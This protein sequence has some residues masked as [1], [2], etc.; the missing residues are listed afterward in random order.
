MEAPKDSVLEKLLQAHRSRS[1][2]MI[3]E[4]TNDLPAETPSTPTPQ[5]QQQQPK[6]PS[7]GRRA[8]IQQ[9][10]VTTPTGASTPKPAAVNEFLGSVTHAR[11]FHQ[12][13]IVGLLE[14]CRGVAELYQ[15]QQQLS[16]ISTD[17]HAGATRALGE[18]LAYLKLTDTINELAPMYSKSLV[19]SLLVFLDRYNKQ[20]HV[21][22]QLEARANAEI[23]QERA[24]AMK[25]KHRAASQ[26]KNTQVVTENDNPF[27][28]EEEGDKP[29]QTESSR[30]DG[31]TSSES[32][33]SDSFNEELRAAQLK[34]FDLEEEKA[35][36]M[37]LCKQ[38]IFDWELLDNT[39]Q[40]GVPAQ[41]IQRAAISVADSTLDP[42]GEWIYM[43]EQ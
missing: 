30:A 32:G 22:Q 15:P 26:S 12:T 31:K 37:Q 6:N 25:E 18:V 14:A 28:G 2:K 11:K 39:L 35:A 8:S 21:Y 17:P 42:R 20:L 9:K 36:W 27:E 29:Q 4:F 40:K 13:L 19:N 41:A 33:L 16:V 7:M 34:L 5:P 10:S 3:G 43:L 23:A 38:T 1:L 24:V